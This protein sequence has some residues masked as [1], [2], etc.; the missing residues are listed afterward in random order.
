MSKRKTAFLVMPARMKELWPWVC[1]LTAFEYGDPEELSKLILA[2]QEV[3][4]EFI[5]PIA[6]IV[7]QKR[8][9]NYKAGSKLKIPARERQKVASSLSAVLGILDSIRYDLI[10]EDEQLKGAVL[11]GDRLGMEPKEVIEELS[12]ERRQVYEEGAKDLGVSIQTLKIILADFE[13][14]IRNW[15]K[16]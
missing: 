3:P 5:A 4:P 15:P 14:K 9:P 7:S 13:K 2:A 8:K 10:D 11:A 12:Q 16:I 1:A 6:E